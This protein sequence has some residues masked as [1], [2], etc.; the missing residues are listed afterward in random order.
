MNA[1]VWHDTLV[2][3]PAPDRTRRRSSLR[4]LLLLLLIATPL[5]A[6]CL[7][8]HA[9][10][11]VSRDDKVSGQIIAAVKPRDDKDKGPQFNDNLAFSQKV[12]VSAYRADGYVGSQARFSDLTLAE[13]PQLANLSRDATGVDISLRRAGDLVILEGRVDLTN[14]TDPEADV[15][16]SAQF[17]GEVTSTNGDRIDNGAVEWK[18]KPGVV[19]T[20]NAQSRFTDPSTRS[21]T[22]AALWLGLSACLVA[23]IIAALAW[24]DHDRSS[25]RYASA[26]QDEDL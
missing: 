12:S 22:A 13:L 25:P 8:V 6:G 11:T 18:L 5:L 17:P 21:F 7:R 26:G 3:S 4:V 9:S 20:M 24:R 1:G 2:P 14:V 23:G 15:T 10:I 19:T 16:F